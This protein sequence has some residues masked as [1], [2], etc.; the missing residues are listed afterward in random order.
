MVSVPPTVRQHQ[1]S[2]PPRRFT[3]A[4]I[5]AAK[6]TDLPELLSSLGYHVKRVGRYHTTKE[7]DSLR[8]KDRHTW[9][10]YSESQ[11][12]DAIAFLQHFLDMPFPEA[13]RY[14]LAFNGNSVDSPISPPMQRT[15]PPPLRERPPFVL[16][17]R[18][19][20]NERVYAYLRG[21]GIG[22][23][24]IDGFIRAGLLYEDAEHHNC[25]FVGHDGAGKAVFAAKRGTWG[26]FRGD[27]AGSDKRVAFRLPCDP[28][29]DD[30]HVFEAPIDLMSWL[31]LYEQPISN[32]IALCGLYDGPLE[33]YLYEH[34]HI[35]RIVLCL[36]ADGPGYEAA[37][38]LDE[39]Y[40]ALG[41]KMETRAPPSGKD[42]NEY[43]K[44]KA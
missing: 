30:V 12:G 10:R 32:A 25:V 4:E 43:L 15:R 8:I 34:S 29:Q 19:S 3:D 13:V 20:D 33:T 31:T 39:K 35:K 38:M 17:P 28:A 9:Y 22:P 26:T 7:M 44:I 37:G 42:W 14:L 27:V 16:P 21:R 24:V 6:D 23:G 5:E 2:P 1:A 11:G 36:D 40:R 41:Y 18:N